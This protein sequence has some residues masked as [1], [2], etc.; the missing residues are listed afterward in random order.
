MVMRNVLDASALDDG[1]HQAGRGGLLGDGGNR[2]P[3]RVPPPPPSNARWRRSGRRPAAR[4]RRGCAARRWVKRRRRRASRPAA[5]SAFASD[6]VSTASP[7]PALPAA[8]AVRTEAA[9]RIR[10]VVHGVVGHDG[11]TL[12]PCAASP[13]ASL[14]PRCPPAAAARVPWPCGQMSRSPAPDWTCSGARSTGMPRLPVHGRVAGPIV[15]TRYRPGSHWLSV[16]RRAP[17]PCSSAP[18]RW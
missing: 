8:R 9:G 10:R 4:G 7:R 5:S 14:A 16:P 6:G 13:S 2:Q 1:G 3:Q 17:R 18:G 11:W 12:A 15:A